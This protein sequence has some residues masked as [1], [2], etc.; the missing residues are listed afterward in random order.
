MGSIA[1]H[2][3]IENHVDHLSPVLFAGFHF[4]EKKKKT[5]RSEL[6]IV[7]AV[8]L[9]VQLPGNSTCSS[10]KHQYDT[11]KQT[12]NCQSWESRRLVRSHATS[13]NTKYI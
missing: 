12:Q 6:C 1:N 9:Y 4:V 8:H 11:N 13:Y 2:G 7:Q 10:S 5:T 3:F